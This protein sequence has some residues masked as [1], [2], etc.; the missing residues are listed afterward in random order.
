MNE[1]YNRLIVIISIATLL[2]SLTIAGFFL[3]TIP[4]ASTA[5]CDD[6][7][8]HHIYATYVSQPNIT[9]DGV[10][11]ESAWHLPSVY[12][13]TIQLS[14]DFELLNTVFQSIMHL[15]FIYDRNYVYIL[16]EWNDS[17]V[18]FSDRAMFCWNINCSN[19]TSCMFLQS[20]GMETPNPGERVESWEFTEN[21]LLNQSAGQLRESCFNHTGW[22]NVNNPDVKFGFTFG[23]WLDGTNHY[24]LEMK[25]QMNT[26]AAYS[27]QAT[28]TEFKENVPVRFSAGVE[29]NMPNEEHAISSTCDLNLTTNPKPDAYPLPQGQ[30]SFPYATLLILLGIGVFGSIAIIVTWRIV[31][32]KNN[33]NEKSSNLSR[34]E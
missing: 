1:H 25:R 12:T 6:K 2:G 27:T 26:T 20:G 24:Q 34:H 22:M 23:A 9:I 15:K 16:A 5:I 14:N 10:G 11:N 33:L 18:N 4:G 17:T 32:K 21:G 8:I 28:E 19:Y 30:A 13:Y 7:A 31:Y 29:N 3:P